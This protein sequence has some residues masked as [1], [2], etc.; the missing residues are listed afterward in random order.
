[1]ATVYLAADLKHHRKVALKVLKPELAAVVGAERFLAEI[2]VTANLQ[3]PNILPLY[4]SGTADSFLFYVMP[5]VEGESLRDRLDREH[6]LPVDDAVRIATNLAEALDYAH[7]HGVIHRDIKPANV[8]LLDGKPVISDF[9]IA[10]AVGTA[11]GGRLTE[12]GLSLGTPHYMSPEQATGDAHVGPAT[13]IYALGCVLYEM[14]VGEPPYVG[15]SAQAVL[16]KI[17]QGAP[18]STTE[19]RKSVPQNVDAAIRKAL[20]KVPADRFRGAGDFAKALGDGGFRHGEAVTLA[21]ARGYWN[22]LTVGFAA[23]VAAAVAVA[24]WPRSEPVG[25]ASIF[26]VT[27]SDGAAFANTTTTPVVAISRDGSRFAF[28]GTVRGVAGIYVRDVGELTVRQVRGAEGGSMPKFSPDGS[29]ILFLDQTSG[30][31]L[32][33]VPSNGGAAVTVADSVN[34]L[35]ASLGDDDQVV[36]SRGRALW[37]VSAEGGS[38]SLVAQ[39]DSA[40]GHLAY[41]WPHVLPGRKAALITLFK[42]AISLDN[43]ELGVVSLADGE[44]TEL[45]VPGTNPVYAQSGHVLFAG[46]DG[47]I[48]ALPFSLRRLRVT[49]AAVPVLEGV[50]VRPE[51]AA[52]FALSETGTLI[53]ASGS[54]G[55]AEAEFVWVTRSGEA[56]PVSA[57]ETFTPALTPT[58]SWRLSPDGSRI[59]FDQGRDGDV[60]IWTKEVPDGP[61]SRL[62][63]SERWEYRPNWTPDGL[64]ITFAARPRVTTD[65]SMVLTQRADGTAQ[66]ELTYNGLMAEG[67]WSPDRRWLV[68]RP[69]AFTGSEDARIRDIMALRPGV[70]SVATPLIATAQF[71]EQGPAISGDGR[72]LAYSSDEAG[73]S[74]IFVRPFPNVNDGK[75]QISTDGGIEP[76]W[77][78]NNRELFFVN[79]STREVEAAEFTTTGNTF[80]RERITKM[81]TIPTTFLLATGGNSRSYGVAPDDERFLMARRYGAEDAASSVI[82]VQNFFEKLRAGAGK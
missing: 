74:Q 71:V 75:W 33:R 7:R 23:L 64:S 21:A 12:T 3:H 56:S 13:D 65:S 24:V 73:G 72:W 54:V 43:A 27:L 8:L 55:A 59:A 79:P 19:M 2:T 36:F 80:R 37:R 20:E 62:T 57:G 25:P 45:G 50:Y 15:S 49:G 38:P 48:N 31:R 51:G 26:E 63:F 81:F 40:R 32:R 30:V 70:D 76:V 42:G 10:L 17:I 58:P 16:G 53:Y 69:A 35:G 4:D 46:A 11:G 67:L 41:G 61:M 34:V 6:Q 66:A 82:V 1:M 22:R 78:H 60:D 77:A 39:P 9:G 14:L 47:T 44:V 28:N 68:L 18:V 5:Y 52:D 29:S